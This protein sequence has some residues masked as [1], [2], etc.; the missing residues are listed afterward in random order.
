LWRWTAPHPDW[1]PSDGGADGWE[2]DVGCVYCEVENAILLID[3]LVPEQP[4]ER[5]RFWRALD[6]DVGRVGLPHVMLTCPWHVRSLDQVLDRYPGARLWAHGGGIAALGDTS[7]RV[8]DSLDPDASLPGGASSIDA[9]VGA[10][11]VLI[12]LP[13]HGALVAGDVLLGTDDGGVRVCP[14]DWLADGFT[15]DDART[16][17]RPLLE[18]PIERVLVSHGEPLLEHGHTALARALG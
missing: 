8:T 13:S 5:E 4:D 15:G 1:K 18:L 7:A 3:P 11:E 6:R 17:L 10:G 9:A 2:Q 16:A 14:D 12:W